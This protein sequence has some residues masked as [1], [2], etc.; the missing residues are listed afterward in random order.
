MV[1]SQW[2]LW[3]EGHRLS[4]LYSTGAGNTGACGV[5]QCHVFWF[6]RFD[7]VVNN[8]RFVVI[9]A[10]TR[11]NNDVIAGSRES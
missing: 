1:P 4:G 10:A 8:T 6:H 9:F 2:R 11:E 7:I 5:G 3:S